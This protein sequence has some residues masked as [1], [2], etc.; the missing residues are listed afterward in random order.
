MSSKVY[1]VYKELPAWAKGVTVVG[2]LTVV[3][4][5][6][7]QV[8]KKIREQAA[9]KQNQQAVESAKDEIKVLQQQGMKAT[10]T[11]AQADAMADEIVNAY[12]GADLLLQSAGVTTRVFNK[13]NNDIDFLLLKSSFGVRTYPDA[14]WGNVSNVT[15]EAAIQNEL[16]N[17]T[18]DS[19][20]KILKKKGIKY[21]I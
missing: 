1:Q 20:N 3:Y 9:N 21:T 6:A 8:V 18:I 2:G 19:L 17:T 12:K 10:I 7:S 14:F 15:L 16:F 13:L 11:K 5:F 4:I